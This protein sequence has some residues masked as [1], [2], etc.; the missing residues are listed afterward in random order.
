MLTSRTNRPGSKTGKND[1]RAL[2]LVPVIIAV[3][4]AAVALPRSVVPG[5]A[6]LPVPDMAKVEARLSADAARAHALT[7]R[8]PLPSSARAVGSAVRAFFGAQARGEPDESVAP[9]HDRI[10]E[11]VRYAE[12][13]D[14]IGALVD[15]RAVYVEELAARLAE[16]SAQNVA[17]TAELDELA[18][19]IVARL[20]EAGLGDGVR[21]HLSAVEAKVLYRQVFA[22]TLGLQGRPELAPSLDEERLRY[23]ILLGRGRPGRVDSRELSM[24]PSSAPMANG[25]NGAESATQ[26]CDRYAIVAGQLLAAWR[27]T[28]VR[29][30]GAIDPTYPTEYAIGILAYQHGDY[31]ASVHAMRDWID[32]HPHGAYA[33]RAENVLRASLAAA[34]KS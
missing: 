15:L 20:S 27:L 28:K 29:E 5:D 30:I 9:L 1:G 8:G 2:A 4:F 6:P 31:D 3:L 11:A 13:A 23:A 18:G 21:L 34:T 26:R 24:L 7:L 19:P 16:A 14:G 25:A 33:L 12:E 22:A 32:Q 10:M 17:R